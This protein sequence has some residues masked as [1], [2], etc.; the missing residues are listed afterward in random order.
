MS[1]S[2]KND[3]SKNQEFGITGDFVLIAT[4]VNPVICAL[5]EIGIQVTALPSHAQ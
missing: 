5:S 4:D 1:E 2:I 3:Q